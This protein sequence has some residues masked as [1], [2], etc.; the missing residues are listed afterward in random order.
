MACLVRDIIGN[1]LIT[2]DVLNTQTLIK[3]NMRKNPTLSKW[4]PSGL[5]G[6]A[7]AGL[8]SLVQAQTAVNPQTFDT[9]AG[10]WIVWNGWGIQGF[11]LT[12]DP[13]LD[14]GGDP[15]SG[16]LRYEVPFTG[17]G[18]E[19]FMTFGTL[20]N[21]W[22]WDDRVVI[23][24]AG[25]YTN[26]SFDILVDPNTAPT[27]NNNY[28]P[29]EIGLVMKGW[30]THGQGTYT[31][32]LSATNWTHVSQPIDQTTADLDKVTGVYVKMWS[33]GA[34]TNTMTFNIDNIWI[35]PVPTN[36]PPV[37]P[38]SMTIESPVR[39]LNFIAAGSGQY[40]RQ[41]IRTVNPEYSWVGKGNNPVSY[42]FTVNSYPGTNNPNFEI[43]T[44][45]V[46][47]PYD[48][49]TGAGTLDTQSAPDWGQTNCIFMELQ[50]KADGSATFTFRWKTNSIPDGNGTYYSSPLGVLTEPK[51]PLGTW[52]LSF[53]NDT[54]VTLT[55]PSGS[56]TN[57]EF[58]AD[59]LAGYVDSSNAALPLY[60]YIGA[61]PQ[62]LTNRALAAV[63][64]AV[65]VQGLAA[66]IDDNFM[67]DS[68]L[69][70]NIW[71]LAANNAGAVQLITAES[72]YWVGWTLPDAGFGFQMASAWGTNNWTD[73]K[74]TPFLSGLGKKVLISTSDVPGTNQGYFR[75]I[76]RAF[77]KLQVLM[78]GET[79]APG[80]ATGKIG[81]PDSQVMGV[82]FTVAVNA[83]DDTWHIISVAANDTITLTSSDESA[84][85]P[86]EAPL[87]A[88]TRNFTV[89]FS[90]EG[91][92][93]ITAT[94]TTDTAKK[95]DTGS[96]T[97]VTP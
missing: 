56:T 65:K 62:E 31:I 82:P 79:N 53:V 38:P 26:L 96:A 18:G 35:E 61:K 43:H 17:A 70:T 37:P 14:A 39:G 10:S 92:F 36:A 74:A 4:I 67:A 32:P 8:T 3:E 97:T 48:P 42:S 23:N 88:G 93:T 57:F 20:G 80:T 60:Y 28:G 90:T 73:S 21:G 30:G 78:P 5:A 45:L 76:K 49:S 7:L 85:L 86:T 46:P 47:V 81:T 58:S 84:L 54:N 87:M 1:D 44:Y 52:T 94:D 27:K 34:Y 13:T 63:V 15:N 89:T 75:L 83:V 69:N 91:S 40:D 50:N 29:L 12:Q 9:G 95:A 33:D 6:L 16:S 22:G 72:L 19:Q 24:C 64:S 68:V 25:T 77:S 55:G 59:K 41:N 2:K 71:E 11:P 66:N 51:G